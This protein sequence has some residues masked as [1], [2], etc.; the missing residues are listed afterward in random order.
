[1]YI[2]TVSGDTRKYTGIHN[3]QVRFQRKKRRIN[4]LTKTFTFIIVCKCG[5]I[6]FQ[7]KRRSLRQLLSSSPKHCFQLGFLSCQLFPNSAVD[8]PQ[9]ITAVCG[10]HHLWIATLRTVLYSSIGAHC[11]FFFIV[12]LQI[13][14]F[15]SFP[16]AIWKILIL[17][18]FHLC[19]NGKPNRAGAD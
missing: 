15:T 16:A 7:K 17:I 6:L 9:T 5:Q 4:C 18:S 1:M 2:L 3:V 8:E 14:G 13:L 10:H 19:G 12:L 11:A